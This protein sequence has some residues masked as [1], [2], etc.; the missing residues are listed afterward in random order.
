MRARLNGDRYIEVEVSCVECGDPIF[1]PLSTGECCRTALDQYLRD[2]SI[3]VLLD[4][5]S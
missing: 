1:S 4:E 5:V 2:Y 3:K